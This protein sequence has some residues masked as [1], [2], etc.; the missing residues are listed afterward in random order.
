M[1][2]TQAIEQMRPGKTVRRVSESLVKHRSG[3]IQEEGCEGCKLVEMFDETGMSHRVM[4]GQHSK[5]S[6]PPTAEMIDATD[7]IVIPEKR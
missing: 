6:C 2:W 4:V 5:Y 7:W 3:G 1:N